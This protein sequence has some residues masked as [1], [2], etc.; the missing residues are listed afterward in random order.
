MSCEEPAQLALLRALRKPERIGQHV[1]VP[2][3]DLETV[4]TSLQMNAVPLTLV[5][6]RLRQDPKG[7]D[8][9]SSCVV[10]G[11]RSAAGMHL[12]IPCQITDASGEH[13]YLKA[14]RS[15]GDVAA[16]GRGEGHFELM[17]GTGVYTGLA[18]RC[19]YNTK[20]L[21]N[22]RVVTRTDCDWQRR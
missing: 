15:V 9:L 3:L 10:F 1:L 21:A 2:E 13:L 22:G 8:S 11:T 18:G 19:A 16:G 4:C 5:E 20:Y 6:H 12:E 14:K 7:R 17:G